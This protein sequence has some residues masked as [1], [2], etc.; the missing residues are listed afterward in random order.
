MGK[1]NNS[2]GYTGPHFI[3]NAD[4]LQPGD[5]ILERGYEW[6]SKKICEQTGSR[7]SHAMIFVGGTIIE[8]TRTGGVFSRIPNRSTV[9]EKNDFLVLRLKEKPDTEVIKKICNHALYLVGS[10]YSV[11]EALSVKGPRFLKEF[12]ENSRKQFCSRLVAQC[13]QEGGINLVDDINFCSPAD[14]EN[15]IDLLQEVKGAILRASEG[16][17]RHALALSPHAG[18]TDNTV[19]FVNMAIEVFKNHGIKMVGSPYGEVVI[20]TLNDISWA[21]YQNKDVPGL[22]EELTEAMYASGYLDHINVDREKNPFRYDY[23]LFKLKVETA[24]GG[25]KNELFEIIRQEVNNAVG[26]LERR[27]QSYIMA[28]ENIKTGLKYAEAEFSAP[29]GMLLIIKDRLIIIERYSA[30][31]KNTPGFKEINDMS[32]KFIEY[33]REYAPEI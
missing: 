29:K 12:S 24:S 8:A 20:T 6:Y 30:Q 32:M 21:L 28:R 5:I 3:L 17:V 26:I 27:L 10:Q 11:S 13:Y 16:E 19:N 2:C 25:D 9:H 14:I 15:S 31:F 22:D 33:I 4:Y 23:A 18:H 7:Y 1:A